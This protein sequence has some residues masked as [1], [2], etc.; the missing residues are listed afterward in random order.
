MSFHLRFQE[1]TT[2]KIS[3]HVCVFLSFID[4]KAILRK[5]W[6]RVK[7]SLIW[8]GQGLEITD[9]LQMRIYGEHYTCT[10]LCQQSEILLRGLDVKI[11]TDWQAMSLCTF[12]GLRSAQKYLNGIL[13]LPVGMCCST[14]Y[15]IRLLLNGRSKVWVLMEFR[16]KCSPCP[17]P[18][19]SR[20]E[21]VALLSDGSLLVCSH[22]TDS[23]IRF[24][25]TT[26][27]YRWYAPPQL[28]SKNKAETSMSHYSFALL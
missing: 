3:V 9:H 5:P 6:P 12:L 16:K 18:F 22:Y 26:G 2:V 4:Q 10:L 21:D 28:D 25:S 19:I 15:T 7:L 8:A 1:I 23:V 11:W 17:C 20:P 27:K 24:N 14:V 13:H